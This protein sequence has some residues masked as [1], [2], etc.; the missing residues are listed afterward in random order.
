MRKSGELSIWWGLLPHVA[1]II[2]LYLLHS[3]WWAL[4]LE[5]II[6]GSGLAVASLHGWRPLAGTLAR[7]HLVPTLIHLLA[8][9]A[10]FLVWQNQNTD[11][12]RALLASIQVNRNT[13]WLAILLHCTAVPLLEELFWRGALLTKGRGLATSDILFAVYHI[14]ILILFVPTPLWPLSVVILMGAAWM[15]RREVQRSNGVLPAIIFHAAADL[16]L[17][18]TVSILVF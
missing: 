14:L 4:A 3:A 9:P 7:R 18:V 8:G 1:L 6:L 11:A 17:L 15:W 13:M 10:L 2:G 16:S 5:G 12:L